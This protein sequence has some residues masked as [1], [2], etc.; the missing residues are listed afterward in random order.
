MYTKIVV[1]IGASSGIGLETARLYLKNGCVVYSL[2]RHNCNLEGV[3][4]LIVDI[5]NTDSL[6]LALKNIFEKEGRID[7]LINSAGFSMNAPLEYTNVSDMRYLFDVNFFG[8]AEAIRASLPYMKEC[9][10]HIVNVSSMAALYP[11]PFD[12]FYTS[13]KAA[14]NALTCAL[15]LELKPFNIR[16]TSLMPG[17]TRTSFTKKRK[18]YPPKA[19]GEYA[20]ASQNASTSLALTEQN[21]S[22]PKSVAKAIFNLTQKSNPPAIIAA[23]PLNKILHLA[24]NFLPQ[25]LIERLLITKYKL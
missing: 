13:S 11:I 1:I 5:V 2:A 8:A 12:S 10:G 4:S 21:G 20:S 19:C 16:L 14:L 3:F 6:K 25:R 9:G 15:R 17:G 18:I 22:A 23:C 7:I 24:F